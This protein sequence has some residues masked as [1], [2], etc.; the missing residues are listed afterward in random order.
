MIYIKNQDKLKKEAKKAKYIINMG[1]FDGLMINI[2][3]KVDILYI[4]IIDM[5]HK[6]RLTSGFF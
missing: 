2:D 4:K 1:Y 5:Y 6:V 3:K